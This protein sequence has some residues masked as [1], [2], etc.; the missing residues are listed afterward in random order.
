MARGTP[1]W[2]PAAPNPR[3]GPRSAISTPRRCAPRRLPTWWSMRSGPISSGCSPTA[4]STLPSRPAT[5]ISS[6]NTRHRVPLLW[7]PPSSTTA[8]E[9]HACLIGEESARGVLVIGAT[10]FV[11]SYA[12]KA[13]QDAG[14]SVRAL[15]RTPA[16]LET[17]TA[18]VGVDLTPLET[19]EGDIADAAAVADAVDGCDAVVH[20][21]AVVGTDP[22]S[23]A[24]IEASNFAGTLNVLGSAADAGSDPIMH[25]PSTAA[26]FPFSTDPVTGDHPVGSSR[27]P[28]A[29]SKAD[30]ERL[31]RRLQDSGARRGR[32]RCPRRC[33][34]RGA[35]WATSP[36]DSAS[37]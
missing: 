14:H 21:A 24:D 19:I 10:G 27:M 20:A 4:T 33:S 16:K 36:A 32:C 18:R 5:A 15:V 30:S 31:A 26:L 22:S 8:V 12:A 7:P 17:V 29:R 23:E 13:L 9:A 35:G 2:P 37:T 11:E 3:P 25:V 6:P 28:Y 34:Q 1:T